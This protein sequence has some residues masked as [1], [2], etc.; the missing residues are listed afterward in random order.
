MV[1]PEDT[2]LKI[3]GNGSGVSCNIWPCQE[4][5][6]KRNLTI[7]FSLLSLRLVTLQK[8]KRTCVSVHG[9]GVGTQEA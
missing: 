7:H 6:P 5:I 8:T 1:S 4:I 9:G 2:A 3:N